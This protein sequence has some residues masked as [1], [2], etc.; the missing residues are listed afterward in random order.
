M[1]QYWEYWAD[2][3]IGALADA[4]AGWTR[5]WD[6]AGATLAIVADASAPSGKALRI[7]KTAGDRFL[8]TMDAIDS[9]PNRANIEVLLLVRFPATLIEGQNL[10]GATGRASG[11]GTTETGYVSN[12]NAGGGLLNG[13]VSIYSA[14][15]SLTAI[16]SESMGSMAAHQGGEF[17]VRLNCQGTTITRALAPR[18][19]PTVENADSATNMALSAA[20]WAGIFAFTSGVVMDILAVG[21]ATNGDTATIDDS[22]PAAST[23]TLRDD[24]ERSSVNV[25]ASSITGAGDSAVISIKP[26]LQESEA[27]SNQSR[28][29]EP[30]VRVDGVNG[31]RPTF[32]F[33]DY[34]AVAAAGKFHGAPWQSTHKPMFSYD[35]VT[36]HYFDTVTVGA[37]DITFR[38]DTAFASGTVYIG[39]SRQMSVAQIGAWL[40]EMA[41]AHPT[42]FAPTAAATAF[43]PT[44]TTWPAQVFIADEFAAQTDELDRAIPG[45]PFYAAVIDDPAYT[46]AKKGVVFTSG[47]HAGEDHA[48][49]IL[50]AWIEHIL[51]SSTD[52]QYIRSKYR[53]WL[54]PMLN[55]PGRAGGGWR[56]SFTQG[57]GGADDANRHFSEAASGLEIIDIPKAVIVSDL[58]SGDVAWAADFHGAYS[59]TWGLYENETVDTAFRTR[60]ATAQGVAWTDKGTSVNDSVSKWLGD[61]FGVA[62]APTLEFGD[63]SPVSDA[64]ITDSAVAFAS[65][66]K[67]MAVEGLLPLPS[68]SPTVNDLTAVDLVTSAP[69]L[70]TP[71]L[72]QIHALVAIGLTTSPPVLGT[73]ILGVGGRTLFSLSQLQE[74]DVA[75][76]NQGGRVPV[77]F[78]Q[79]ESVERNVFFFM[80][81]GTT[82][83]SDLS[84]YTARMDL[85]E[86]PGDPVPLVTL[87]SETNE[88][89][90]ADTGLITWEIPGS[91]T[92]TFEAMSFGGD[93]FVYA[94]D[95]D[96]VMVCGFDFEMTLSH[97]RRA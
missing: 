77:R 51:G 41:A 9:D 88:I 22:E 3:S 95:G 87:S 73:P 16:L 14:G 35:R 82:P 26:R 36:W 84:A 66:I 97:T 69:V 10:V 56:G 13:R 64:D 28:W 62:F 12:M 72:G 67:A 7:T 43:T 78:V 89:A 1:A 15:T 80:P 74:A 79:G 47:V 65:V 90:L 91:V 86:Y 59:N 11:N 25:S 50:A 19:T 75:T 71:A 92:D 23:Y 93:L 94:P 17:Y 20:G 40:E 8:L 70:G 49:F 34:A 21:I 61:Y 33:K 52:A 48:N 53:I 38:H 81:D 60:M 85:R 57:A 83:V 42:V 29:L 46:A 18:A 44:L 58:T 31:L 32:K 68:S 54:Y 2:E 24:F 76:I 96:A 39:R 6:S 55:A 37:S 45:T 63:V 5:R 27:A 30:S 4:P